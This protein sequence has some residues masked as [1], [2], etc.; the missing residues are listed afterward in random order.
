M[1]SYCR[2]LFLS[3]VEL[4]SLIFLH[5]ET[6]FLCSVSLYVVFVYIFCLENNWAF[7]FVIFTLE[8]QFREEK[9]IY[10]TYKILVTYYWSL[11]KQ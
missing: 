7:K 11:F 5:L 8:K 1:L 4:Y 10:C 2:G 6:I 3:S 9:S